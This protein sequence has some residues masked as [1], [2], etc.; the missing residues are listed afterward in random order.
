M[1]R[2]LSNQRFHT[3]STVLSLVA[4]VVSLLSIWFSLCVLGHRDSS[5]FLA[6]LLLF[7]CS[8][9]L[10]LVLLGRPVLYPVEDVSCHISKKDVVAISHQLLQLS[11]TVH[12]EGI[13]DGG[14]KR[15]LDN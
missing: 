11:P 12:S 9:L 15:A 2:H 5:L 14:G 6:C 3:S 13:Q 8:G 4:V 7:H 1:L 10:T